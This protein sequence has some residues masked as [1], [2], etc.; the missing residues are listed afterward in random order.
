MDRDLRHLSLQ[1][2]YLIN[3]PARLPVVFRGGPFFARMQPEPHR[4]RE[5][6]STR[7]SPLPHTIRNRPKFWL[8]ILNRTAVKE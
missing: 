8:Q 3:T 2:R 1:G 7:R 4:F 5:E 6:A